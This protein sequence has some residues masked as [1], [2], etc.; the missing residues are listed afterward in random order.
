[1]WTQPARSE[2]WR[3]EGAGGAVGGTRASGSAGVEQQRMQLLARRGDACGSGRHAARWSASA[4]ARG[5]DL[6]RRAVRHQALGRRINARGG[7]VAR[8]A[9]SAEVRG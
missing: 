8:G 5:L 4:G 2:Q 3:A 1:M 9:G 6:G 7:V